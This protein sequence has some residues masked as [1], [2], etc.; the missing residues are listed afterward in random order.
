MKETNPIKVQSTLNALLLSPIS[1][2]RL[3]RDQRK[4]VLTMM[5]GGN[6]SVLP[7]VYATL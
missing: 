7:T 2:L 1:F 3:K 4:K 6:Y 5:Y